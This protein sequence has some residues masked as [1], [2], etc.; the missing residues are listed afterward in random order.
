MNS[1]MPTTLPQ[2]DQPLMC[3]LA[4]LFLS[5]AAI[6]S[7]DPVNGSKAVAGL[8]IG[9]LIWAAGFSK[10]G[11]RTTENT[12]RALFIN[13]ILMAHLAFLPLIVLLTKG[14]PRSAVACSVASVVASIGAYIYGLSKE[15]PL[16]ENLYLSSRGAAFAI[17]VLVFTT[18]PGTA[19]LS[20]VAALLAE[21]AYAIGLIVLKPLPSEPGT[22][23]KVAGISALKAIAGNTIITTPPPVQ[24]VPATKCEMCPEL[25][26]GSVTSSDACFA[27]NNVVKQLQARSMANAREK[28]PSTFGLTASERKC[29]LKTSG[30]L[31]AFCEQDGGCVYANTVPTG[32][33]CIYSIGD[34]NKELASMQAISDRHVRNNDG[35]LTMDEQ[36]AAMTQPF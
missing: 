2:L 31:C 33:S 13:S 17:V 9:L 11:E 8:V 6:R 30:V 22:V 32:S 20:V 19:P 15:V 23:P 7:G 36:L 5:A 29:L 10:V 34:I 16:E 26:K 28:L 35:V 24:V 4:T 25:L 18:W 12:E 1:E 27:R 21:L 3:Q 14:N